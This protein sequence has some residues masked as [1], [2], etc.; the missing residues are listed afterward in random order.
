MIQNEISDFQKGWELNTCGNIN[1]DLFTVFLTLAAWANIWPWLR[2]IRL[3]KRIVWVRFQKNMISECKTDGAGVHLKL[4][5]IN[6]KMG[7]CQK[8]ITDHGKI[9]AEQK[10]CNN[11]S[12]K[13]FLLRTWRCWGWRWCSPRARPGGVPCLAQ[14]RTHNWWCVVWQHRSALPR[15]AQ[16]VSSH[17]PRQPHSFYGPGTAAEWRRSHGA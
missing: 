12:V 14:L 16:P 5:S 8:N 13:L 11:P 10:N 4:K 9:H 3:I 7:F 2:R 15:L 6:G 1:D 17:Q